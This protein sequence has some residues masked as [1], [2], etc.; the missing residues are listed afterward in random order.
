MI[1]LLGG[2]GYIGEAFGAELSKRGHA[3][4]SISRKEVDYTNF[5]ELTALLRRLK[6]KFV[7]NSAG[8]TGRPNV[9]ACELF[10]AETLLGNV[11]LPLTLAQACSGEGIPWGHVSSGC[12]YSGAK[13]LQGTSV[14]VEKNLL[15]PSVK[16]RIDA[17]PEQLLGFA[18]TDAPNFSFRSPPCSFYSGS[19]ALGEES[20]QP[21]G[22]AYVWRL[23]IPFDHM[24][25]P[26]NY[27]TKVQKYP[28]VYD[29]FNSLS[30]RGDF[31]S[32]C[33]DLWEKKAPLGLY[34]VT[35]FGWVTTRKVVEMVQ[36][37]L[38]PDRKFEF[39]KNDEEFYNQAAKTPRSN[40]IMDVSKLTDA[41]VKI[42]SVE[43]ALI[44]SLENWKSQ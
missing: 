35:N 32:A 37:I 10:K 7:I 39:W 44:Y 20:I 36:S 33:L 30:H 16:K 1:L 43:E 14:V 15:N 12:I 40:C 19:K 22:N 42:R 25:N 11:L 23:R 31:V 9:D 41:G 2:S 6:P 17:H 4:A 3:F 26:R 21:I 24:D 29:N 28:K 34:N 18:E 38:E 13:I 27:L 5:K 8:F